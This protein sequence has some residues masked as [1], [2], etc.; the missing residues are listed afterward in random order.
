MFVFFL[1]LGIFLGRRAL[2][3]E[4]PLRAWCGCMFALALGTLAKGPQIIPFAAL[5]LA[6]FILDFDL[7]LES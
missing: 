4:R 5:A 3:G 2:A 7:Y 6:G 1:T